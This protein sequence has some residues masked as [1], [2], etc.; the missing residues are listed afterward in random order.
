VNLYVRLSAPYIWAICDK[1]GQVDSHGIAADLP[2]VPVPDKIDRLIG[3]VPGEEVVIHH[4]TIPARNQKKLDSAIPYA[5]EERLAANVEDVFFAILDRDRNGRTSVAVV[6]H[7]RMNSWL[8]AA[9]K[10]SRSLD[11]MVPEYALLPLHPQAAHTVADTG[12][13][14]CIRGRKV[15]GMCLDTEDIKLWWAEL[16]DGTVSLAVN[17]IDLARSLVK[18]GGNLVNQWDI[19]GSFPDWLRFGIPQIESFDLLRGQYRPA[20]QHGRSGGLVAA[21]I[22]LLLALLLR[23][24]FDGYQYFHLR[25]QER[26]LDDS[27]VQTLQ[28]AFPGARV[29]ASGTEKAD[30]SARLQRLQTGAGD[31]EFQR[32]LSIMAKAL[33]NAKLTSVKVEAISYRGRELILTCSTDSFEKLNTLRTALTNERY[34]EAT[35]TSSS[36]VESKVTGK[37]SIKKKS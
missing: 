20:H 7:T 28:K 3:V 37:F 9:D 15:E 23:L 25:S 6:E 22:M 18:Q 21:V 1:N 24:G 19:G 4:V 30:M 27:L 5:L 13:G 10:L 11:S 8:A 14:V 2:E 31:G 26:S 32:L 12:N 36:S 17:D 34:V 35:L 33:G 16:N 29:Q